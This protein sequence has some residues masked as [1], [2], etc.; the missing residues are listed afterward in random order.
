[1]VQPSGMTCDGFSFSVQSH[2]VLWRSEIWKED[3]ISSNG[4]WSPQPAQVYLLSN[5]HTS[6]SSAQIHS[7]KYIQLLFCF[8]IQVLKSS[9]SFRVSPP[10][11]FLTPPVCCRKLG[12]IMCHL[13]LTGCSLIYIFS[14]FVLPQLRETSFLRRNH[15]VTVQTASPSNRHSMQAATTH[16]TTHLS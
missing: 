14:I 2:D 10:P 12:S 15:S 1:M 3:V 8:P 7:A 9:V 5:T 16:P 6:D 13:F 11:S 4:G